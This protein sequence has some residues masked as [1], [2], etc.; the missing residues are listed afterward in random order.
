MQVRYRILQK[1]NDFKIQEFNKGLLMW[2]WR[3]IYRKYYGSEGDVYHQ[4]V[5][6]HSLEEA[7]R[8][9]EEIKKQRNA[10]NTYWRIVGL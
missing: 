1:G 2:R 8:G 4:I 9:I 5:I 7:Q 3:D 6:F 10:K